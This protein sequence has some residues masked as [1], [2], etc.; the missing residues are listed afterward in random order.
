MG[1]EMAAILSVVS[2][3]KSLCCTLE[4]K[5]TSY[6]NYTS[7]V[8]KKKKNLIVF[9]SKEIAKTSVTS[10]WEILCKSINSL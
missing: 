4:T 8:K 1:T 2:I 9:L 5:R 7:I 10:I 6:V 3:V